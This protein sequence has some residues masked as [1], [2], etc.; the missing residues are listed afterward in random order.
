M[1][2]KLRLRF[3]E[4]HFNLRNWRT[5]NQN[6]REKIN[7]TGYIPEKVFQNSKILGLTW[8]EEKDVFI[9]D[10]AKFFEAASKQKPTKRNILSILSSFYDPTGFIQPL[11]VTMKVLFQ[12]ICKSKINWDDKL[13]EELKVRWF[14]I[15]KNIS[16]NSYFEIIR[17]Y[18]K[19]DDDKSVK[20][21]ELHGFSDANPKAY[22]GCV[23]LVKK[24][25]LS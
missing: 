22:G 14:K 17:P 18:L 24:S 9:F 23:Y 19:I 5:N 2:E 25:M 15:I 21:Y 12:D 8:D 20:S 1:Y 11:I 13:S 3:L 10:F 6:L 7:E 4:G 16:D